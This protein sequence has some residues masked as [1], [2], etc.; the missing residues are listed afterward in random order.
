M[1]GKRAVIYARSAIFQEQGTNFALAEQIH[2]CRQYATGKGYT[3]VEELQ[4]IGSGNNVDR[5][6]LRL[7]LEKAVTREFE[8]LVIHDFSRLAR[9]PELLNTLL[10]LFEEVGVKVKSATEY[11]S[12]SA[13]MTVI[14]E[15]FV[16]LER[17]KIDG[18]KRQA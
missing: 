10:G 2:Q 14:Q 17:R 3:V 9:K 16:N 7:A 8:V 15:E 13:M 6:M 4:E 18:R 12:L 5:A 11:V 1:E